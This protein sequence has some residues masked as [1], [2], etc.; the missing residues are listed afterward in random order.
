ME[1]DNGSHV[2]SAQ[3]TQLAIASI[4]S[5]PANETNHVTLGLRVCRP[6]QQTGSTRVTQQSQQQQQQQLDK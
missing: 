6:G 5:S 2:T 3:Q 1:T 4:A